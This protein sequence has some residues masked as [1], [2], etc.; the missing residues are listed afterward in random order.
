MIPIGTMLYIYNLKPNHWKIIGQNMIDTIV[1]IL[2]SIE[3][4]LVNKIDNDETNCKI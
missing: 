2:R 1:V 4:L 3:W